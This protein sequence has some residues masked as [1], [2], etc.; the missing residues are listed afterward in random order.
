MYWGVYLV[1]CF[2]M[3][4]VVPVKVNVLFPTH[5]LPEHSFWVPQ[6]P[7]EQRVSHYEL[8][9]TLPATAH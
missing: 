3:C 1:W 9:L 2:G 6:H 8:T 7:S 4:P 5:H